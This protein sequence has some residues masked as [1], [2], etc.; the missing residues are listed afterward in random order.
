MAIDEPSILEEDGAAV[1]DSVGSD[2]L[3]PGEGAASSPS[4]DADE[5]WQWVRSERLR[6][7]V[8]SGSSAWEVC[9]SG[10]HGSPPSALFGRSGALFQPSG[11]F[12]DAEDD[13]VRTDLVDAAVSLGLVSVELLPR[14]L[15]RAWIENGAGS[16]EV[17]STSARA[18]LKLVSDLPRHA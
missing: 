11:P 17:S 1:H 9:G 8:W 12:H 6:R 15:L 18:I 10:S 4:H 7:A 14:D 2:T 3:E 13:T 5:H 16:R